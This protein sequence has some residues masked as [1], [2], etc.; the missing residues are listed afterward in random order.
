MKKQVY[1]QLTLFQE[2]SPVNRSQLPGSAEARTMTVTSGLRCLE[3]YGNSSPLGSLV[4]MCL[5]SSIWHSTRC[6]LIWKQKATP[7]KRSL[8]RLVVSM[9]RTEETEC[10]FWPT[11]KASSPMGGCTGARKTLQKM[12]QKGLITEEERRAFGSGNGG[13]INPELLEWLMGYEQAFT[14]LIPT[15]TATDYKGGALTRWYPFGSYK[16]VTNRGG[17]T[18]Q[19]I[20]RLAERVSGMHSAWEDWPGEPELDRVVDGI[21]N[22]VDRIKCLGNAVVPQ[23][24]YPFFAAIVA[25]EEGTE[26]TRSS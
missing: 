19:Q 17:K 12:A 22:R 18:E 6:C 21:P 26:S 10:V 14:G 24:F 25:I 15:P 20:S 13:K 8:F 7:A 11:P 9:P 1:E 4:R 2:D 23:Q 5:E 16:T 3:S